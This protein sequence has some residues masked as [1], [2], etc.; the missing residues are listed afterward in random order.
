MVTGSTSGG[1]AGSAK[2]RIIDMLK[3]DHKKVKKAFK[4]FEKLDSQED[5]E[6][7]EAL[8]QQ[9]CAEL[10]V[11]AELEEQVFYPAAREAMKEDDLIE[12]AEV[13]HMTAKVLI[14]QLK[15]MSLDDEKFA[16][17]FKVLGEYINHHVKEE[18]G[19]MFPKARKEVDTA[20]LGKKLAARKAQLMEEMAREGDGAKQRRAPAPRATSGTA[21]DRRA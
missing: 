10:E 9:T 15:Q 2:N 18:E 14:Q 16:A 7:C 17:T 5:A 13:E 4:D 21:R 11:H 6:G 1:S 12:E 20:A 8:V 3:A 19:E